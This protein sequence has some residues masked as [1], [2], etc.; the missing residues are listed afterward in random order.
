MNIPKPK[1]NVADKVSVRCDEYPGVPFPATV[2]AVWW[3][4]KYNQHEY[5]V[6]EADGCESDGYTDEW[7][8]PENARAM[9]PATESDHGK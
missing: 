8:S 1:Y 3:C 6:M 2:S 7:L 4:S 9:P 5:C